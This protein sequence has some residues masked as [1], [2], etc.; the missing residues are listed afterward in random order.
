MTSKL[1]SYIAMYICNDRHYI[2]FT[3]ELSYEL[4]K[5]KFMSLF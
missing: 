5:N 3:L 2:I 4:Q 1:Y